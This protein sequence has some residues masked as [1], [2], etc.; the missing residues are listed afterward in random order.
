M[1]GHRLARS[2][3]REGGNTHRGLPGTIDASE[4][5]GSGP[6][7][8]LKK[9]KKECRFSLAALPQTPVARAMDRVR[10]A[11]INV[12][13]DKFGGRAVNE[14]GR[15]GGERARGRGKRKRSRVLSSR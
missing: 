5:G 9:R 6:E 14:G 2:V 15:R 3:G 12:L 8:P 7:E 11:G 13:G 4:R 1:N 10:G